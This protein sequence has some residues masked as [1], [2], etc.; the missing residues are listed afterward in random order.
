M[1]SLI[2][3]MFGVAML[4]LGGGAAHVRDQHVLHADHFATKQRGFSGC[5]A[6]WMACRKTM[7]R[8]VFEGNPED[9]ADDPSECGD[10][11]NACYE[12]IAEK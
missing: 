8:P 6:G 4:L 3:V 9:A 12:A 11:W 2:V 1:K 5:D 10:G 7:G